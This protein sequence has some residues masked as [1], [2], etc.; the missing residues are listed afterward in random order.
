MTSDAEAFVWVWLPGATEPVVAGR[1]EQRDGLV[2]FNYG[3]SYLAREDA[4]ALYLPELPLVRGAIPPR[5]ALQM[6]GCIDDASPDSWG[7]R[8]IMD[9]LLGARAVDAD[10]A[11]IGPVTYLLQSGSDRIGALDFQASA[12]DYAPRTTPASLA[13]L[14]DAADR[15]DRR[16]E[17][18]TAINEALL[19]G[20]SIGGAR[21]KA[22]LTD[23]DHKLIAKFSSSSDVYPVVEGEYVAMELARRVGIDVVAVRLEHVLGR[24]V[25]LI[26]RFDRAHVSAGWTRRLVVSVLTMLELQE[27]QARYAT[28]H[29]FAEIVRARFRRPKATLHELFDRIAFNVLVGNTDDHA[30]NHAAFWNG[31]ELELT[32]AYDICPQLRSGRE[33]N[34]AMEIA[35][36]SRTARLRACVDAAELYGLTEAEARARVDAQVEVIRRDWDEVC[37]DAQLAQV[38]RDYFWERQ[39]LNDYAFEGY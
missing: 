35:P 33:A 22:L 13:D 21:P 39:F 7:M 1:V 28:Y 32:P 4:I 2:S 17:L 12:E 27:M 16:V 34:Q 5:G 31:T 29:E 20:S 30:R 11:E 26:D 37:D 38:D 9:K 10:P 25:L 15:V 14:L 8:V 36:G 18:P 6:A 3:R 19:H 23:G 24:S